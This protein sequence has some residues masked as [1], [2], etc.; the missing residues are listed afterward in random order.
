[1]PVPD[2]PVEHPEHGSSPAEHPEPDTG[3][4]TNDDPTTAPRRCSVRVT[5]T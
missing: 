3:H 4:R 2:M 5:A 1:M